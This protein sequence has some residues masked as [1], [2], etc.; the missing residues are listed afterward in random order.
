M[1]IP[2]SDLV[3]YWSVFPKTILHVG[4]HEG[5]EMTE[6]R[7]YWTPEIYW[8]E[9]QPEKAREVARLASGSKDKVIEAAVWDVDDAE[10]QLN[11]MN[12]T[13]SSSLLNLGTHTKE[14]PDVEFSH[15]I[16]VYTKRLETLIPEDFNPEF[17]A[18]DIQGAE[19][20]ALRGFGN[21]IENVKWIYTE[22]NRE[23]L[24]DG[25][26]LIGDLDAYLSKFDFKRVATRWTR[27]NWGDALY[28]RRGTLEE[29]SK[30]KRLLWNLS[31]FFYAGRLFLQKLKGYLRLKI[32]N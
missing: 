20:H 11:I 25:C 16:T 19:L 18:L 9:A 7:N 3:K 5:E 4:A 17:I 24:Y 1:L 23:Y 31:Q 29:I 21:R 26:C 30:F 12:N 27:N 2:V 6:Y 32:S 22:V 28:V 15:S 14:H 8:I 10:L 13:Q